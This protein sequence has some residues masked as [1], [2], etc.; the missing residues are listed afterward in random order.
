MLASRRICESNVQLGS[1]MS[2]LPIELNGA[3][4]DVIE[5][6]SVLIDDVWLMDMQEFEPW[7]GEGRQG[8][9]ALSKV[10]VSRLP[11]AIYPWC[12]RFDPVTRNFRESN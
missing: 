8:V 12:Q 6:F 3:H 4:I 2:H 11:V 5:P 1:A 9:H 10:A 7:R